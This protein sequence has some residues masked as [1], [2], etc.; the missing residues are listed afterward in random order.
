MELQQQSLGSALFLQK[1]VVLDQWYF[2]LGPDRL[3]RRMS[4]RNGVLVHVETLNYGLSPSE[5]GRSCKAR[6]LVVGLSAGEIYLRCGEPLWMERRQS[7]FRLANPSHRVG[8]ASVDYQTWVY[9]FGRGKLE[10][11]L[12]F[13][14]GVLVK[15]DRGRRH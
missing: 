13:E 11:I 8:L 4:F 10:R 3:M 1:D 15:I 14:N 5:I 12:S 6:L 9:A 7:G 2:N